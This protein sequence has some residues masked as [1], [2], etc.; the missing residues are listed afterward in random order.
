MESESTGGQDAR[1]SAGMDGVG[2]EHADDVEK[3]AGVSGFPTGARVMVEIETPCLCF[4][5]RRSDGGVDFV[6]PVPSPFDYGFVPGTVAADG[7]PQ[8]AIVF[9][10]RRL[11]RFQRVEGTVFGRVRFTDAGACDD[12]LL[13]E[14]EGGCVRLTAFRRLRVVAFFTFYSMVKKAVN[15][16]RGKAGRTA[17][18]GIDAV[19]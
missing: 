10:G 17:F 11:K 2:A 8:D 18:E 7:D 16:L 5:K 6:S 19:R 14:S 15:A 13:V 12:K 4:V 3:G 1:R 9:G